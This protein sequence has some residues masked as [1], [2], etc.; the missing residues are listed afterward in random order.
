MEENK[1]YHMTL[2]ERI[3]IEQGLYQGKRF[4]EIASIIGKDQTT[5]SK[6]IRR[7]VNTKEIEEDP[8]DCIYVSNCREKNMCESKCNSF[9]KYCITVDCTKFC[10]RHK[11]KHC[12]KLSK[13]PYVCN[14]CSKKVSCHLGKKYYRA[15]EAQR[16]YEKRLVESRQGINK[17]KAELT[18]LNDLVSPLLKMNQPINH[19]FSNHKEE[20]GI[21]RKTLYNYIDLGVL[22]ARNIDLPRK[23]KYK[24][25][26]TTN[27]VR[28]N[29]FSYRNGR[30]YKEFEIFSKENSELDVVEMDTVKGSNQAGKCILT[31]LFR[32]TGLMLMFLLQRCTSDEVVRVFDYLNETLGDSVF[33]RTFPIILTDNGS[34]FK[35]VNRLERN[36]NNKIRTRVFYCDPSNSN[37]KSRLER[38]HEYIRYIIPKGR[39]MRNLTED[40]VNLMMNHINSVSRDYLNGHSPAELSQLLL[41]RKVLDALNINIIHPDDVKLHPTLLKK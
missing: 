38:N 2:S 24:K 27:N 4:K 5:V 29:D 40:N 35:N 21:S 3:V 32:S 18:A 6:E 13:P 22:D 33:K 30:T 17:T 25:R 23:V 26:K 10:K 16:M 37:Q 34:E 41:N 7:V 15:S 36:S 31:M 20:L 11:P 1:N 19:I 12:P 14:A 39:S 8:V 9:C 28:T